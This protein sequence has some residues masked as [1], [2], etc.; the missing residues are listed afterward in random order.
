MSPK[1]AAKVYTADDDLPVQATA[2]GVHIIESGPTAPWSAG[3]P[4]VIRVIHVRPG[5]TAHMTGRSLEITAGEGADRTTVHVLDYFRAPQHFRFEPLSDETAWT[6]KQLT[7][8]HSPPLLP[9]SFHGV[10]LGVYADLDADPW[11]APLLYADGIKDPAMVK[12]V[13]AISTELRRDTTLRF[14]PSKGTAPER[15]ATESPLRWSRP[16]RTSVSRMSIDPREDSP[17]KGAPSEDIA[18]DL[19]AVR[20]YLRLKGLPADVAN[21]IQSSTTHQLRRVHRLLAAASDGRAA[22]PA[23]FIDAYAAS[24][25][26]TPLNAARH[27]ALLRSLAARAL[28]WAYVEA[29]LRHDLSS[30]ALLAFE[31]WASQHAEGGLGG[32]HAIRALE[33]FDRL[34][35]GS[36]GADA[37]ITP[38]TPALLAIA[39]RLDGRP[40]DV[41]DTLAGAMVAVTLDRDWIDGML[42]AGIDKLDM[43]KRLHGAKVSV[44]DLVIGNANRHL[45]EGGGDRSAL[46]QV[47]TS[48]GLRAPPVPV[49]R[50]V[51]KGYLDLGD[52]GR[53]TMKNPGGDYDLYPGDVLD[54]GGNAPEL[55]AYRRELKEATA[56]LRR[57]FE[58][59]YTGGQ[60]SAFRQ[61]YYDGL[62]SYQRK[63][64]AW[65]DYLRERLPVSSVIRLLDAGSVEAVSTTVTETAWGGRSL[66]GNLVD[67]HGT[68][69]EITAWRPAPRPLPLETGQ[70]IRFDFQ[71]A[72]ALDRLSLVIAADPSGP[73]PDGRTQGSWKV[74]ALAADGQWLDV[75]PGSVI[76]NDSDEIFWDIETQ[77][78]PYRSYRLMSE[79]GAIPADVWFTEMSF[80]TAEAGAEPRIAELGDIGDAPDDVKARAT[81]GP[82][83]QASPPSAAALLAQAMASGSAIGTAGSPASTAGMPAGREP[84]P[85][86]AP[87]MLA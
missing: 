76:R 69:G 44:Q 72:I 35:D 22:L 14:E 87:A 21:A 71:H 67:G 79:H 65:Q 17:A 45:Y 77:G 6:M 58:S 3:T 23:S 30:Q 43:L 75:A 34:L 24:S 46:V 38:D 54:Q 70:F 41:I 32:A 20:T 13:S 52:N 59:D 2:P 83:A 8:E 60:T 55:A 42:R 50:Y 48:A 9:Q 57:Q 62:T 86:L 26:D 12:A 19:A 61:N 84:F 74:Q 1:S 56:R 33:E 68:A 4:R 80:F 66:P 53:P 47:S 29:V 73:V 28:P 39:L 49:T 63:E 81:A 11:I 18:H 27:G 40:A 37:A 5:A 16:V 78:R 15:A 10:W 82:A 51:A 85:A 31:A 36:H 7:R 25:V 64:N